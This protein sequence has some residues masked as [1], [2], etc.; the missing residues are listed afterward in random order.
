MLTQL[1][2]SPQLSS[3]NK[4]MTKESPLWPLKHLPQSVSLG[5]FASFQIHIQAFSTLSSAP[6]P[7]SATGLLFPSFWQRFANEELW[8]EMHGRWKMGSMGYFPNCLQK[9]QLELAEL[10]GRKSTPSLKGLCKSLPLNSRLH[11]FLPSGW[12]MGNKHISCYHALGYC[13]TPVVPLHPHL[14]K[15][16]LCK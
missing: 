6:E 13:T 7:G 16:S 1:S 2:L 12:G 15:Q 14:Y 10:L 8:Q 5:P 3:S 9:G 11:P 4:K